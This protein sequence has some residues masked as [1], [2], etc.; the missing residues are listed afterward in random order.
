MIIIFFIQLT[1]FTP[2]EDSTLYLNVKPHMTFIKKN[3]ANNL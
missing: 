2:F 1:H 3:Q